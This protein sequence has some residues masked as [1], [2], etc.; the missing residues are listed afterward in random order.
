MRGMAGAVGFSILLALGGCS[1]MGTMYSSCDQKNERFSEVAA[2]TKT[3][4]KSDSRYGFHNGYIGYA[5]RA[6]A[7]LDMLDEKVTSGVIGEKEARYKMQ[8][9]LASMQTQIA[10]EVNA[11]DVPSSRSAVRT[12][13][14]AIGSS[15][16]CTS[17]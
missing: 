6:M 17:R 15:I 2:C 13:C 9:I 3:A 14:T 1:T 16:S 12:N 8:E 10:S 7:A 5:N 4:L 11:I